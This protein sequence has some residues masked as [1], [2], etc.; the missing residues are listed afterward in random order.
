MVASQIPVEV[1]HDT[2]LLSRS[3]I[4]TI[5]TTHL[6]HFLSVPFHLLQSTPQFFLPFL[7]QLHKL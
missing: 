3:V 6:R 5:F 1:V 4:L 7:Q 2:T